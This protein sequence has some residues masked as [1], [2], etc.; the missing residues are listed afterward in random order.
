M[1]SA[2][3]KHLPAAV[4]ASIGCS[5]AFKA[6]SRLPMAAMRDTEKEAS[7]SWNY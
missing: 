3:S 7:R 1:P 4:L 6:A 2:S 5:V